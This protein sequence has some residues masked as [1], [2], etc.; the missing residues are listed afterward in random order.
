MARPR[1]AKVRTQ[2]YESDEIKA[3]AEE[4]I[5]EFHGLLKEARFWFGTEVREDV[6]TEKVLEPRVQDW[7]KWGR[8][9][10]ANKVDLEVEHWHFRLILQGNAWE[11]MS[12]EDKIGSV[13]WMLAKCEMRN[14]KP[15]KSPGDAPEFY[16]AVYRRRGP[17]NKSLQV[18]EAA[19]KGRQ[20]PRE[21]GTLDLDGAA[22]GDV[23]G[24]EGEAE[25]EKPAATKKTVSKGKPPST[26]KP[27]MAP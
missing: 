3:I 17:F 13:D 11:R 25:A 16:A 21:P 27:G 14:G 2:V 9:E 19:V 22:D 5:P 24:P 12:D 10:V 4:L 18:I 7:M 15:R 6:S 1:K 20:A 26:P 23:A 8:I